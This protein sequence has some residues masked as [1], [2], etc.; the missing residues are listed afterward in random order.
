M[1]S[2]QLALAF[3][4]LFCFVLQTTVKSWN[5]TG[6][7]RPHPYNDKNECLFELLGDE[8]LIKDKHKGLIASLSQ[9]RRSR[10]F[11]PQ[12]YDEVLNEV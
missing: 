8:A 7:L 4:G 12:Q 6:L 3:Q 10:K 1:H 9:R 11:T 5:Q 2:R